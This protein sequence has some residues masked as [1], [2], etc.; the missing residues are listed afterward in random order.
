[1]AHERVISNQELNSLE[2]SHNSGEIIQTGTGTILAFQQESYDASSN[3]EFNLLD[4]NDR[5]VILVKSESNPSP[6]PTRGSTPSNFPTPGRKPSR[7]VPGVNPYRTAPKIVDNGL[8]LGAN[9]A[10]PGGGGGNAEFDDTCPA[11]QKQKLDEINSEHQSFYSTQSRKKQSS[12]QW[13]L[14]EEFKSVVEIVH[15]IK[16]NPS[17]VRE[18]EKAGRDHDAQ[19]SINHLIEQLS[20]GNPNPGIGTEHLFKNV[21]ELRGKNRARVYYRK[22]DGKIEILGKSAKKNQGK[23]INILKKMYG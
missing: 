6:L 15:R 19:K 3:E 2:A 1:M 5:Q 17:L 23:V 21:Y 22:V 9:P 4:Q 18:A 10:G 20:L 13:E 11:P 12:E 8:G 7:P 16:D 14:E